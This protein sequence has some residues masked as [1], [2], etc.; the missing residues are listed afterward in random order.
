MKIKKKIDLGVRNLL[1]QGKT[2]PL[3][4]YRK[5]AIYINFGP[6]KGKNL[7]KYYKE[8]PDNCLEY[9]DN[10]VDHEETPF[11][12]KII[13]QQVQQDLINNYYEI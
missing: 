1:M 7:C 6:Q 12:L 8:D 13:T 9:L 2:I 5:D 10:I 3:F 11:K 4:E